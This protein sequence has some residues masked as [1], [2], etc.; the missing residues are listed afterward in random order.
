MIKIEVVKYNEFIKSILVKGH[1]NYSNGEDIVC[2]AV[3]SV[4][5]TA[6]LGLNNVLNLNID[7][8]RKDGYL[9]FKIPEKLNEEKQIHCE[10]ILKTMLEG[11]K[12]IQNGYQ[13]FVKVEEK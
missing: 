7:F 8:V 9:S 4:V 2:A 1:A 13:K 12:D 5:Q 11:L 10:V 6:L 3:S